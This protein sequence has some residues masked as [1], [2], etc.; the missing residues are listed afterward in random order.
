MRGRP[1]KTPNAPTAPAALAVAV[2][3][4][5]RRPRR[6]KEEMAMDKQI[7]ADKKAFLKAEKDFLR[8]KK[9]E[10]KAIAKAQKKKV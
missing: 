3:P 1:R 7:K 9:Q 10:D 6:T 5:V 8:A 4:K 2:A